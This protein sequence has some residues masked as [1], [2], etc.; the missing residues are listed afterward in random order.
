MLINPTRALR[1]ELSVPGDKSIS[2]RSVIFGALSEGA[3]RISHFLMS[4][5]CR[6]TIDCF[7]KLG[8]SIEERGDEVMI[9]GVG[10]HGLSAPKT[11][12]YT[13]NSGTTTRLLAGLLAA[14]DFDSVLDGDAS[15]RT[16][17]M[18]RVA[19]PLR[20]MGAQIETTNGDFC[21]LHLHGSP[22]HGMDYTLPVA[23]AQLKS[24]LILAGLYAEGETIIRE[25]TPSRN[26]TEHMLAHLGAPVHA[27]HGVITVS[28]AAQL[29]AFDMTVPGDIS[30]AAFFLVAGLIVPDSKILLKNVGLN[31]TRSGVITLLRAMGGDITVLPR[32]DSLEPRGDLLVRASRL[33]GIEIGGA[34]IPNVIDE[35]PILAV[36]AAYA[37]GE[38]RIFDAAELRHK[39]S[40]RIAAMCAMLKKCGVSLAETPDGMILY[41]GKQPHG[42]ALTSYHD[43]RVAMAM[44]VC[45]LGASSPSTLEDAGAVTISY[46]E[47]FEDLKTLS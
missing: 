8:V 3:C 17:P 2:H 47:F 30:S 37:E 21:P 5:D 15:I 29:R 11:T 39:E 27:Q 6:A 7:R 22:L 25:R 13:A 31:P 9:H 38:T 33:H 16:R 40:D 44:T 41:G 1:G 28:R 43:H 23:S 32:A 19:A 36:A 18:A 35:L 10:L 45:A 26:H 14:Q 24:A 42:A 12:L 34:I 46:P 4:D 20:Q